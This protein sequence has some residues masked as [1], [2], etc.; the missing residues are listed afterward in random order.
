M[1][2][3]SQFDADHFGL[4]KV[5]RRLTEYLPVVR[6]RALIAQDAEMEQTK[7]QE[8]TLKKAIE[9]PSAGDGQKENELRAA[10]R[11]GC[12]GTRAHGAHVERS[13]CRLE[14]RLHCLECL[15]R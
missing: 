8:V 15:Q 4:D 9:G 2:H 6:L 1:S 7:A 5:K 14:P 10:R 13:H 12:D 3:K 11:G